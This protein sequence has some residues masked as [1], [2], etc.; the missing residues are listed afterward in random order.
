M[1]GFKQRAAEPNTIE[2][3]IGEYSA[4]SKPHQ[5]GYILRDIVDQMD[6][7]QFGR[8]TDKHELSR[9]AEKIQRMGNEGATAANATRPALLSAPWCAWSI[10][11]R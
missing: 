8:Q 9:Y 7:L 5:S 6:E 11:D 3:K 1:H 10:P 4:K 2:Y